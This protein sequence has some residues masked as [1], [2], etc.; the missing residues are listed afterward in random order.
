MDFKFFGGMSEEEIE[1][2]LVE[3]EKS[4]DVRRT[5]DGGWFLTEQ[6][7]RTVKEKLRGTDEPS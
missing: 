7:V 4:G 6:G 5:K 2:H 1:K 3:L